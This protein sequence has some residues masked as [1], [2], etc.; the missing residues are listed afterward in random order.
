MNEFLNQF[1]IESREHVDQATDGLL[2][3]EK[4]P[5]DAEKIDSVFRAF[6]T[7]KGGA[8]IIEF[9]AMERAVHAAEDI[10]N[11]ARTQTR[12]LTTTLV[13]DCL[14]CLDQVVQWM[15]A[16]ERSGA[17]PTS[18]DA[19]A[20]RIVSRLRG[21]P[22]ATNTATP[23]WP[24]QLLE[25]HAGARGRATMALRFLPDPDAFYQGEDPLAQ[26]TSLPGLLALE[27][28]PREAW[29]SLDALNPFLCNL[30]LLAVSESADIVV[31]DHLKSRGGVLETHT[32]AGTG[33]TAGHHSLT[34]PVRALLGAQRDLIGQAKPDNFAGFVGSAGIAAQ[35][36]LRSC[37]RDADATRVSQAT[38][39]SLEHRSSDVLLKVLSDLIEDPP[40]APARVAPAPNPEQ[41]AGRTLRIDAARIDELVRLTGQIMVA[42]NG[43]G[44]V[45]KLA[46][47]ERNAISSLLHQQHGVLERLVGELQRAVLGMRVLP[48]RF[49]L[50]RLPRVIREMSASLGKPV[51]LLIE[52]EDTE[53][54]KTIVEMLFE[55]MLH[56]VR[57][58]VDHGIENPA[59]RVARGKPPTAEIRVHARRQ[60]EQVLVE[61]SDDGGG[62]DVERVRAVAMARGV[63]NEEALRS[64]SEQD[65]LELVFAPGFSTATQVTELSG[66]GVGMDAVRTAVARV[67]GR[68]S[69]D[70]R[71]GQGTTVRFSLP[72]SVMMTH[73]MTVEAGGQMFG[74]P[75]DVVVE[76]VSLPRS[77]L[78]A[79]GAAQA[80]VLRDRTI[81][82]LDLAEVL[83]FTQQV[84]PEDGNV[85]VV[86][87]AFGGQY[88]G[89]RVDSLGERLEVILK[90]L[91]GLL[92]GMPGVTGTTL[93]GDG[94][95]LLVLDAA[96]LLS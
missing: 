35:N 31:G 50:Q 27:V 6:H 79:I 58:A 28:R 48:L 73:V 85:I 57:N 64:M 82:V 59:D 4:T 55:P 38:A 93:L 52:G 23:V 87:T 13:G 15:D 34:A 21:A 89:L 94:R 70:S 8:G 78:A 12:P 16:I 62:I 83:G 84:A 44:H 56:I 33:A 66:R 39:S 24:A 40:P 68:V 37:G 81:P 5:Q 92:A 96:E 30:E 14:A 10:L 22:P 75:L 26:I 77:A 95:V 41:L 45:A 20:D 49:V 51:K 88:G 46:Q 60:G 71:A 9:R 1:L 76:T 90:P 3:L 42:K 65:I 72:F 29:P 19:E 80:I 7:L 11:A 2:A 61:I 67:G 25:K 18:S 53:A 36:A 54:D 17:V 47:A 91:D 32:F 86:I 63:V 43:M 74:V 69:I